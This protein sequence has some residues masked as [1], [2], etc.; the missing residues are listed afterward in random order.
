MCEI[1]IS[2]TKGETI[3][4]FIFIK[5]LVDC[6]CDDLNKKKNPNKKVIKF[7]LKFLQDALFSQ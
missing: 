5:F 7:F 1:D 4:F 6:D 3:N 2:Y